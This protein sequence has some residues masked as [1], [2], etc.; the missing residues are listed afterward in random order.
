MKQMSSSSEE[1]S[2]TKGKHGTLW[3]FQTKN[4]D[5]SIDRY[6]IK[7]AIDRE[8]K[9]GIWTEIQIEI[10]TRTVVGIW[11][12]LLG[13]LNP[14]Q[15]TLVQ[16]AKIRFE[17]ANSFGF[18]PS[19][20]IWTS[21]ICEIV[22]WTLVKHHQTS[23]EN[24]FSCRTSVFFE[25][26]NGWV[27]TA[28][29]HATQPGIWG[30]MGLR[31]HQV[32]HQT[33]QLWFCRFVRNLAVKQN[34]K[35]EKH[36]KN[37]VN[38]PYQIRFVDSLSPTP[39][40]SRVE[41]STNHASWVVPTSPE[42]QRV[43]VKI[44]QTDTPLTPL[45][46]SAGFVVPPVAGALA[47]VVLCINNFYM[48]SPPQESRSVCSLM[49]RKKKTLWIVVYSRRRIMFLA[50]CWYKWPDLKYNMIHQYPSYGM[51]K[52]NTISRKS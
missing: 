39:T 37:K 51:Q 26:P 14:S 2:P 1:V 25:S 42:H 44:N 36:I 23:I 28:H 8:T 38:V 41:F 50:E 22:T 45:W 11:I 13:M 17:T 15:Q 27:W 21:Q 52:H 30:P 7:K 3:L 43:W 16:K 34:V 33:H 40:Q 29:L 12:Y 4:I 10:H 46:Q 19:Q 49:F 20:Q 9:K 31:A 6:K 24:H 35:R 18:D 5:M 47:S 32:V 48:D